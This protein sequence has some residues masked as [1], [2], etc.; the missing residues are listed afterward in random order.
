MQAS[1]L[2]PPI[3]LAGAPK[4]EL[5]SQPVYHMVY[6]CSRRYFIHI[7]SFNSLRTTVYRKPTHTDN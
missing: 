5:I 3:C 1:I 7:S 6:H 2:V 4:F